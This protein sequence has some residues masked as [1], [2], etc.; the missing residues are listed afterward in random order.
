MD[1]NV[2]C[3]PKYST[4]EAPNNNPT[5]APPEKTAVNMPCPIAR[6]SENFSR[7]IENATA[8]IAKPMPCIILAMSLTD[9]SID[10]QPSNVPKL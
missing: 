8:N 2:I 4:I 10:R 9:I 5:T 3:Q 7:I 6:L 1:K